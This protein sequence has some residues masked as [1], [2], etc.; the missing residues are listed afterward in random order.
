MGLW[1]CKSE[2]VAHRGVRVIYSL[3]QA[4]TAGLLIFG[5]CREYTVCDYS[6]FSPEAQSCS[7]WELVV[8]W[9]EMQQPVQWDKYR[10]FY[11]IVVMREGW[12]CQVCL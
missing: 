6:A 12:Y 2:A 1:L 4:F 5:M 9:D 7:G 3:P 8:S 11:F 10:S